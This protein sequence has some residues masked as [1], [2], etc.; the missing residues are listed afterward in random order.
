MPLKLLIV[1]D[2][3][4]PY[5]VIKQEFARLET[6]NVEISGFDWDTGG[7]TQ[8]THA[9]RLIEREGPEAVEPPM[10]LLENIENMDIL[11]VQYCP[12]P[13][14]ALELAKNLKVVGIMRA[15]I[16]NIDIGAAQKLGIAILNVRGRNAGAVAEFTL[17]I[18]LAE[19]RNIARSH[20]CLMKGEWRRKYSNTE[21]TPNLSGK[22][23]GIIG[24][25]EVG[26]RLVALLKGFDTRKILLYDPYVS[27]EVIISLGTEKASLKQLCEEADF[28][29]VNARLTEETKHLISGKELS[30]MRPN[31][32]IVNTARA[33]LIDEKALAQALMRKQILGA[34]IDVFEDEPLPHNHPFL[35]LDNI[36]LTPHLAGSTV[37]SFRY[38]AQLLAED[39]F[40]LLTGQ[41]I[42]Y[43]TTPEIVSE[44]NW[45]RSL[46]LDT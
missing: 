26:R 21:F 30:I 24:L 5:H 40:R 38:S 12:I 17:G 42:N 39:L 11:A 19:V 41:P 13:R 43:T 9:N 3:M 14:K 4:L 31:V 1:G 7:I 33:G 35:E 23:F 8:L 27:E 25:G 10:V 29:S 15:G 45:R 36:T 16:E 20:H 34:A 28:I 37:D 18:L 32:F 6:M 44:R 2:A 46:G 22:I